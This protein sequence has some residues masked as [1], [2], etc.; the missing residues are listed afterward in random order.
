MI[1]INKTRYK[2]L[3][4]HGLANGKYTPMSALRHIEADFLSWEDVDV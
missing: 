4:I 2:G 1:R 3:E